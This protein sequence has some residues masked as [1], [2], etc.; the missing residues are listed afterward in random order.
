M[1]VGNA[2]SREV[3]GRELDLHLVPGE[4]ADVVLAHLPG[5]G[6]ENRMSPVDLHPEHGARERLGDLSFD[7]DLLFFVRHS[8]FLYVRTKTRRGYSRRG[9]VMVAKPPFSWIFP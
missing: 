1:S 6:G 8:P 2:A 9:G 4:D 3:V 7:L 5:D